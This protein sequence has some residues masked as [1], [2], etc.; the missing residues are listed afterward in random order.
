MA[1]AQDEK[2]EQTDPGSASGAGAGVLYPKLDIHSS[3]QDNVINTKN[4]HFPTAITDVRNDLKFGTQNGGN[5]DDGD[6][7][8]LAGQTD[9]Q[10]G[11]GIF[12]NESAQNKTP[13]FYGALVE[14]NKAKR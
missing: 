3:V 6:R 4:R 14:E 10:D 7:R 8:L 5:C 9:R 2:N 1:R 13:P 11:L 12:H